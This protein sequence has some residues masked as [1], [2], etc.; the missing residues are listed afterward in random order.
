M[1]RTVARLLVIVVSA[2]AG[3]AVARTLEAP[4]AAGG[5]I[6][7]LAGVVAILLE[8]LAASLPIERLFWGVAGGLTGAAW[9]LFTGSVVGFVTMTIFYARAV[10]RLQEPQV[11]AHTAIRHTSIAEPDHDTC[12]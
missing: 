1:T 11:A 10:R 4:G 3:G 5:A 7:A 6:G 9:G 2:A 8:A 12:P